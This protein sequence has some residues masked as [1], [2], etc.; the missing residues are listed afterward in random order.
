MSRE[1][2]ADAQEVL[3]EPAEFIAHF[4]HFPPGADPSTDRVIRVSP[5]IVYV[6][7]NAINQNVSLR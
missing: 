2:F 4:G 5:L 1:V 6:G 3:P 7:W